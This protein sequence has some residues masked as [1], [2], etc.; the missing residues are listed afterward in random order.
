M[1]IN[2]VQLMIIMQQ[3]LLYFHYILLIV[4][5]PLFF[6]ILFFLLLYITL[7]YLDPPSLYACLI[8]YSYNTLQEF[9][10]EECTGVVL[11]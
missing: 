7:F 5:T 4:H 10:T 9:I 3:A 2:C 1:R 11:D 6:I 8:L